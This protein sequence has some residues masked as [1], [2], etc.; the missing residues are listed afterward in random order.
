MKNRS[1]ITVF[2]IIIFFSSCKD[3]ENIQAKY[4][5]SQKGEASWYGPGFNGKKTANGEVFDMNKY[6]AAHKTLKFGTV[7]RVTNLRNSKQVEVTIN[8]RGPASPKRIIDLS[9]RAAQE[10]GMI[11]SGV[12]KVTI[13][14]KK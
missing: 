9:K 3:K 7:V 11:E 4:V 5:L 14:I 2:F 6:T 13:E 1:I 12:E 10:I 8:D